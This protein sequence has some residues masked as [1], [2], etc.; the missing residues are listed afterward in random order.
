LPSP[1]CNEGLEV[2]PSTSFREEE[3]RPARMAQI[4]TEVK[5]LVCNSQR[6]AAITSKDI[7]DVRAVQRHLD[8][9]A[10]VA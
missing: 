6:N 3:E 9:Q 2:R 5:E 4:V 1:D 7:E 10:E 8:L